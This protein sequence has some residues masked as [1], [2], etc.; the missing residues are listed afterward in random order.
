ME[1]GEECTRD[2]G[3]ENGLARDLGKSS[4]QEGDYD[5]AE[6]R[7][8][9]M[10]TVSP[11]ARAA[12]SI[13][14]KVTDGAAN[15]RGNGFLVDEG[16]GRAGLKEV[17]LLALLGRG[18]LSRW[19]DGDGSR[20]RLDHAESCNDFVEHVRHLVYYQCEALS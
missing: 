11:E 9:N 5:A 8:H 4:I 15:R 1:S 3:A 10:D 19:G 18:L 16:N 12:A 6:Y 13:V 20:E 17:L 7:V 14:D 2:G